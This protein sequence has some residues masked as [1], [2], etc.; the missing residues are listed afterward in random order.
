MRENINTL[1]KH[2]FPRINPHIT[3][4]YDVASFISTVKKKAGKNVKIH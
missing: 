3:Q 4:I 2:G 1:Q